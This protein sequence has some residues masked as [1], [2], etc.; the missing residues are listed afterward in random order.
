MPVLVAGIHVLAAEPVQSRGRPEQVHGCPARFV[1]DDVHGI[2]ST[3][4]Q[5]VSNHLDTNGGQRRA[6]AK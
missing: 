4:L 5:L 1:L 6:T 3:R 2:D